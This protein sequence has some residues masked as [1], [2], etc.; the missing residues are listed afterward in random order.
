MNRR[1]RGFVTCN[2]DT[3][4]LEAMVKVTCPILFALEAQDQRI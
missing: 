3:Y 2:S 4:R 1:H